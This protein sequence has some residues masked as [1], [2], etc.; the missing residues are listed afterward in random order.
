MSPLPLF[1]FLK[2]LPEAECAG[3][4]RVNPGLAVRACV[5]ACVRVCVCVCVYVGGWGAAQRFLAPSCFYNSLS[6][7][8]CPLNGLSWE[9]LSSEKLLES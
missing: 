1:S 4:A 2:I 3:Q 7:D 9:F 8:L 6:T 5:R